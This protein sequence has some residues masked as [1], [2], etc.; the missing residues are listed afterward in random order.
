MQAL[1]QEYGISQNKLAKMVGVT[2][3][4][5]SRDLHGEQ[6]P[7]IRLFVRIARALHVTPGYLLDDETCA[8]ELLPACTEIRNAII[9]RGG[10]ITDAE[11]LNLI[12]MLAST[13]KE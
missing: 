7:S 12:R 4:C 13:G 6:E 5:L 3:S 1:M 9:R 2:P 10:K 11:K 8:P